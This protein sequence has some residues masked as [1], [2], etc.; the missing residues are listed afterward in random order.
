MTIS[1]QVIKPQVVI[2][3]PKEWLAEYPKLIERFG[4]VCYKSENKITDGSASTFIEKIIRSGHLSVIEHL[5]ITVKFICDRTMSHQLV[6]HRIA[7]YSQES[8]RYCD[9]GKSEALQVICPPSVGDIE[10]GLYSSNGTYEL[11]IKEKLWLDSVI[12]SYRTYL[13][14]RNMGVKAE[15]ARMVL[16]NATKTE[17]V[18]TFNLRTWRHVFEERALNSHAQWQIK[19]LMRELLTEF[20]QLLPDFFGDQFNQIKE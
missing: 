3:T 15:D 7:S 20:N 18:T 8:Q 16:P 17:V 10:P 13:A 2:E 1:V 14:L 9:Y 19:E 12:S 5:G 6:R 4:R 11:E